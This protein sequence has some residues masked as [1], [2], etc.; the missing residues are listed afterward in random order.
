MRKILQ[1]SAHDD[2]KWNNIHAIKNEE[3]F[4]Y[5]YKVWL[6]RLTEEVAAGKRSPR[7]LRLESMGDEQERAI[8]VWNYL[9][10]TLCDH[11][12]NFCQNTRIGTPFN[13]VLLLSEALK[14]ANSFEDNYFS[15]LYSMSKKSI[16]LLFSLSRETKINWRAGFRKMTRKEV[17]EWFD[18]R[19]DI[20]IQSKD[21]SNKP[22]LIDYIMNN[23]ISDDDE[24]DDYNKKPGHYPD[25]NLSAN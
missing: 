11:L 5:I 15:I 4:N 18:R 25:L 20:S 7:L 23:I 17:N 14:D 21:F 9:S 10:Q 8:E 13:D 19:S 3:N 22:Q 1:S 6:Q 24:L 12:T 2:K 16:Q